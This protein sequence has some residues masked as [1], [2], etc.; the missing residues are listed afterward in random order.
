MKLCG[1]KSFLAFTRFFF[2][3]RDVEFA[4]LKTRYSAGITVVENLLQKTTKPYQ[5]LKNVEK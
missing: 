3:L 4:L 5:S 2:S 1:A